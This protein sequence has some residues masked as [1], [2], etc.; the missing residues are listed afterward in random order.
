VQKGDAE[1]FLRNGLSLPCSRQ[2][3]EDVVLQLGSLA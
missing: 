1:L 3:R 2:Y